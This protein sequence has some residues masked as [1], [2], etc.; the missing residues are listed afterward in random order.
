MEEKYLFVY[1]RSNW[2]IYL[3]TFSRHLILS[4]IFFFSLKTKIFETYQEGG[5]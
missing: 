5:E 1:Q 3:V 2:S 4:N